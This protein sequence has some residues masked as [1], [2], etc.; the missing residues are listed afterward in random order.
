MASK[1]TKREYSLNSYN[2]TKEFNAQSERN[3]QGFEWR[4]FNLNG[5]KNWDEFKEMFKIGFEC[6][7]FLFNK[8]RDGYTLN[9]KAIRIKKK[10]LKDLLDNEKEININLVNEEVF[11]D[12]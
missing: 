10:E 8:R 4:S 6:L 3:N 12:V 1:L 2:R 11:L 7:D 5:V 9:K